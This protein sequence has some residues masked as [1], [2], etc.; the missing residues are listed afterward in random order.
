MVLLQ[1]F[2]LELAVLVVFRGEHED[3]QVVLDGVFALAGL[4]VPLELPV[5]EEFLELGELQNSILIGIVGVKEVIYL[6]F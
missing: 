4:P 3:Q 6:Q 2:F 5:L 1:L